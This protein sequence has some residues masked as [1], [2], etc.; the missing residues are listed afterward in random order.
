MSLRLST[1]RRAAADRAASGRLWRDSALAVSWLATVA[2]GSTSSAAALTAAGPAPGISRPVHDTRPTQTV[3]AIFHGPVSSS[4]NHFCTA[5]VVDSPKGDLIVTA[6]HCLGSGTAGL[7]FVPG[8]H[9]GVAPY[10]AWALDRV[11]V[12]QRWTKGQD[13]D[14]DVA[15]AT[16]RPLHGRR[17][18]DVVGANTLRTGRPANSVVRLTGYPSSADAPLTCVNRAS[19]FTASQLRIACDA[20][21]GGTSGSPWVTEDHA[22]IGVIGGYQQGGD[23]PDVS[24]SAR[25]GDDIATL[26]R[27]AGAPS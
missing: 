25:F 19:A 16:V 3:G 15:F 11:T 26:Y 8:Y 5:S 21:S 22:V 24:Y 20:Y 12:D 17:V 9:D 10:G 14:L 18:Q 4:G 23:T 27:Q 6:A 1:H 2:L 13:P 7:T